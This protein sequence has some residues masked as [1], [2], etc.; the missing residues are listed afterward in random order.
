MVGVLDRFRKPAYLKR[1]M[2][3]SIAHALDQSRKHAFDLANTC[4]QHVV[5]F[6]GNET[7]IASQQQE[8][9][10]FTR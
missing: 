8:I 9:F 1:S 7:K 6:L 10:K 3:C 2:A 5:L 4:I